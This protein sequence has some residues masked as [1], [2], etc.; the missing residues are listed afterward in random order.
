VFVNPP[1]G[2]GI[3][4]WLERAGEAD[5]AVFLLPARVDTRWFHDLVLPHAREIRFIRGRLK[6][7]GAKHPAPFP[8]MIVVF[9]R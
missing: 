8:S 5:L 3:R 9:G 4:K 6:F 2:P 7:V 1:Y